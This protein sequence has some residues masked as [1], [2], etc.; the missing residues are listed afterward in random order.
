L[1]SPD[2]TQWALS[3]PPGPGSP[4]G[5]DTPS[6]RWG[7]LGKHRNPVGVWLGLPIVTAGMYGL[8]WLYKTNKEIGGYDRRILVRP[9]RAVLACTLGA[10]LVVP[11]FVSVWRLCG[12]VARAQQAAGLAPMAPGVAFALFLVGAGP[13][14]LQTQINKIWARYPSA[15]EGQHVPLAA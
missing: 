3:E 13:L 14:Y 9:G 2:A 7:R 1:T 4:P 11:P 6:L 8:V 5:P 15:V 12:R 10:L